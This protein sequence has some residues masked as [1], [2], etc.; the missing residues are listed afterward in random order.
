[1]T[2]TTCLPVPLPL[3][4][5]WLRRMVED[6]LATWQARR[7]ARAMEADYADLAHL[8][9]KTLRDIGAPA[10]VHEEDRRELLWQLERIR[11]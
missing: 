1:M 5:S 9:E 4:R 3:H 7:T 2:T 10:W 6:L 11:H 8:S